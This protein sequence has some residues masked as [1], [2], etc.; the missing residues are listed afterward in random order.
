MILRSY[1]SESDNKSP[2]RLQVAGPITHT[3]CP[4]VE[5]ADR[6]VPCQQRKTITAAAP[7]NQTMTR[8]SGPVIGAPFCLFCCQRLLG[9]LQHVFNLSHSACRGLCLPRPARGR[10]GDRRYLQADPALGFPVS[11]PLAYRVP[12]GPNSNGAHRVAG[13]LLAPILRRRRAARAAQAE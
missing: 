13:R 12:S 4:L 2:S 8:S 10:T 3:C 7:G 9:A 1:E 5:P 6:L 11:P